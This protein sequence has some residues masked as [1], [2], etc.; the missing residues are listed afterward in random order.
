M[1]DDTDTIDPEPL[2]H[3]RR[4]AQE[5]DVWYAY[6]NEDLGHY[7][8]GRLTFLVTGPTRTFA[9]PP[10]QAPDSPGIGLGWRYWLVG[11]VDLEAGTV[12]KE[13]RP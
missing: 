8:L 11:P 9:V 1:Q 13:A 2:A 6:R 5:G 10:P 3:M 12:R 4:V 7:D